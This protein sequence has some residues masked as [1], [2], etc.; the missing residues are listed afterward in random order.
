MADGP[1]STYPRT[2]NRTASNVAPDVAD[3]LAK[4]LQSR[5]PPSEYLVHIQVTGC[6][7][8]GSISVRIWNSTGIRECEVAYAADHAGSEHPVTSAALEEIE[9]I[10][11]RLRMEHK[12]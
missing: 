11:N 12:L 7:D 6:P 1:H 2:W 4:E 5:W 10:L 3:A 8:S 9:C